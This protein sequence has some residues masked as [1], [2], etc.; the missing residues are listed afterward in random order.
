MELSCQERR[1]TERMESGWNLSDGCE[2]LFAYRGSVRLIAS[3]GSQVFTLRE[4]EGVFIPPL[5]I[6]NAIAS[7][8]EAI[9]HSVLFSP[10]DV[11]PSSADMA[12]LLS[13][14]PPFVSISASAAPRIEEAYS[15]IMEKGSLYELEASILISSLLLLILRELP[16]GGDVQAVQN[17]RLKRMMIFIKDHYGDAVTVRDIAASAFVSERECLRIFSS[18]LGIPPGQFLIS[19]RLREAERLLSGTGM[20]I[21]EI[22]SATGF[23]S[24]SY[25][26]SL[27]R[28]KHGQTPSEYRKRQL[29]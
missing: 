2:L 14:S 4:G 21:S 27:F 3:D 5:T 23:D 10:S 12:G 28:R 9:T 29:S 8:V 25:F 26:A 16:S 20:N 1:L 6:S 22:A 11:L 18:S 7:D 15:V 13:S 19:Y 17:E 24:P